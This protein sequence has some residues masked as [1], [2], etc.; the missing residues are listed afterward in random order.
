M[1]IALALSS[2]ALV[3]YSYCVFQLYALIACWNRCES[4]FDRPLS[5]VVIAAFILLPW[6]A[7]IV[8]VWGLITRMQA[9]RWALFVIMLGGLYSL[10]CGWFYW[11]FGGGMSGGAKTLLWTLAFCTIGIAMIAP[12]PTA[13]FANNKKLRQ[14]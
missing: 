8:A 6:L 4:L 5:L 7:N 2:I 13:F 12:F 3:P 9:K 10:H 1:R 11:Q 14:T